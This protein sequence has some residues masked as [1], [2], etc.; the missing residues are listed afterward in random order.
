MFDKFKKEVLSAFQKVS[1]S[2]IAIENKVELDKYRKNIYGLFHGK[3]NI[4][5]RMFDQ[6]TVIDFGCGTGEIDIVL[7]MLGANVEGFDFNDIS[8]ERANG[9]KKLLVDPD[10]VQFSVG[11]VDEYKIKEDC[12]DFSIS[13]GVIAHVPD[14]ENM[15]R[16]MVKSCKSGGFIVLGYVES[17]G[18]IQR[19]LHRAICNVNSDGSDAEIY[20]IANNLFYEH[21]ERSVRFGGRT[22]E[23]VINDYL[24]NPHYVGI[25][26]K[27]LFEW[28]DKYGV[29]YYSM[30]PSISP[31]FSVDS[32]YHPSVIKNTDIFRGYLS[33]MELRWIFS[34]SEDECVLRDVLELFSNIENDM[35]ILMRD[36]DIILQEFDFDEK[37]VDNLSDQ[38]KNV[39]EKLVAGMD[40]LS[41]YVLSNYSSLTKELVDVVRMISDQANDVKNFD[42]K[43]RSERI[44]RGYNG[45]TT[46]YIVFYKP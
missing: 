22:A 28:M 46:N 17:S 39:E 14:Q 11:D 19:L 18:L 4:P 3:L 27:T 7:S 5:L 40:S 33:L 35:D 42:E 21:I 37:H 41:G 34:Q 9:L 32:P 10:K 1:P 20:N 45:L 15:F 6:S 16:R 2:A 31:P 24:V 13:M 44:F 23:S 30:T 25:R 36:F 38:M 26:I 29:E 43:Y 8:I 12:Y